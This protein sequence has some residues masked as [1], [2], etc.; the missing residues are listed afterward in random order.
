MILKG[1]ISSWFA[2]LSMSVMLCSCNK[3]PVAAFEANSPGALPSVQ[4]TFDASKAHDPDGSIVK[5]SWSFGEGATASGPLA[6]H[7]YNSPGSYTVVLEVTDNDGAT[8][9]TQRKVRVSDFLAASPTRI[10]GVLGGH[11]AQTAVY[12]VDGAKLGITSLGSFVIADLG[13]Q[14]GN[15][16][17]FSGFDLDAVVLATTKCSDATCVKQLQSLVP[18]NFSHERCLLQ[19]GLLRGGSSQPLFG[20]LAIGDRI[21]PSIATLGEFDANST[22]G[23]SANGFVSLGDGGRLIINLPTPIPTADLYIYF[24][25]VGGNEPQS[26]HFLVSEWT[27][28]IPKD[29]PPIVAKTS[30]PLAVLQAPPFYLTYSPDGLPPGTQV[31]MSVENTTGT[32]AA[33][34]LPRTLQF[35]NGR[36]GIL[37]YEAGGVRSDKGGFVQ[38][39]ASG[40]SFVI[41]T[42]GIPGI[43][44]MAPIVL[45]GDFSYNADLAP[46]TWIDVGNQRI[47]VWDVDFPACQAGSCTLSDLNQIF[48]AY[49]RGTSGGHTGP[50]S[51]GV[52]RTTC[53]YQP[54]MVTVTKDPET[55]LAIVKVAAHTPILDQK[56]LV[57]SKAAFDRVIGCSAQEKSYLANQI[58]DHEAIHAL[59]H[60]EWQEGKYGPNIVGEETL[61]MGLS[62][63]RASER[64][65]AMWAG[66]AEW[67]VDYALEEMKR[68]DPLDQDPYY[69][70]MDY[71]KVSCSCA[72]GQLN[73][74]PA[75]PRV[76]CKPASGEAV[77][78]CP[79]NGVNYPTFLE[80]GT[81]CKVTLGCFTNIC[82]QVPKTH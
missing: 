38:Q 43:V 76:N 73:P 79:C 4:I 49:R 77:F 55:G 14:E 35:T 16:G 28:P 26:V 68:Y 12:R 70:K 24:G 1:P 48:D 66:Y 81:A 56:I 39:S 71:S 20:T 52:T 33:S 46:A 82:A 59:T 74:D 72:I 58:R 11:P 61:P 22:S 8:N 36:T 19:S 21:D 40:D 75:R 62:F 7:A 64:E 53:V 65:L 34:L 67:C 29:P 51:F 37:T 80:C 50:L 41:P 31:S 63:D 54:S 78:N 57:P 23:S 10:P 15:G 45:G 47:G 5:Y 30:V 60:I 3:K 2:I 18:L 42:F 32:P 17:K 69:G 13:K 6:V 44:A 27:Y 25:E 9:S